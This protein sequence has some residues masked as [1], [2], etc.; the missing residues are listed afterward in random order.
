VGPGKASTKFFQKTFFVPVPEAGSKG[1]TLSSVPYCRAGGQRV[2]R[3][4]ALPNLEY[5]EA[6][7]GDLSA[8]ILA[9]AVFFAARRSLQ[10]LGVLARRKSQRIT[11]FAKRQHFCHYVEVQK[12]FMRDILFMMGN[13]INPISARYAR[14]N[15]IGNIPY[16]M[17]NMTIGESPLYLNKCKNDIIAELIESTRKMCRTGTGA[18]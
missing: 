16:D 12:A 8:S 15:G 11:C 18:V 5:D 3:W 2:L 13:K 17:R 9:H 14:L 7:A 10:H 1:Q 4:A 6:L